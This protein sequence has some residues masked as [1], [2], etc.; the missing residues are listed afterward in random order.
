MTGKKPATLN[1][2]LARRGAMTELAKRLQITI[3]YLCDIRYGRKTPSLE[4]AL[5]ISRETGVP[6]D[7]LVVRKRRAA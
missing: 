7:A 6:V 4:L 1:Q 2:A 3:G 5:D